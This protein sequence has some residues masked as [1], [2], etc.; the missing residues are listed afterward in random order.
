ML[1]NSYL[2]DYTIYSMRIY[3][4]T[5]VANVSVESVNFKVGNER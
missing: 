3:E 1:S 5:T 4:V 2:S